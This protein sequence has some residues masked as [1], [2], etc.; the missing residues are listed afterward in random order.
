MLPELGARHRQF[1]EMARGAPLAG[2]RIS[3]LALTGFVFLYAL[4]TMLLTAREGQAGET[5][6]AACWLHIGGF[7]LYGWVIGDALVGRGAQGTAAL[8]IYATA[9]VFHLSI[10]ASS[11]AREHGR[12]Y[13]ER[14]RWPLATSVV[15]GWWSAA[16]AP[17]AAIAMA[18]VFAFVA[19]GVLMTSANEELPREKC[20]RFGWFLFGAAAYG[21]MLLT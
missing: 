13:H 9:M 1:Q 7:A 16:Q 19:G 5:G 15:A 20:G 18:R 2:H 10:V 17:L 4:D 6:A 3:L 11:L 12:L 8:W 14:G 21:G